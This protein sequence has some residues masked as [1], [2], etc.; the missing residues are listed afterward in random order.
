MTYDKRFSVLPR[1]GRLFVEAAQHPKEILECDGQPR[2]FLDCLNF[3]RSDLE[4]HV[5]L[6]LMLEPP[7]M[8]KNKIS[9]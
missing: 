2:Q 3:C 8:E 1:K 6:G 4:T 7:V 9:I 5:S